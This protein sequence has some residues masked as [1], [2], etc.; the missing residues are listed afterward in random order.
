MT[1]EELKILAHNT[2]ISI[3]HLDKE[4]LASEISEII[5]FSVQINE[6]NF[7]GIF[8]FEHPL[9][10]Q[11]HLREDIVKDSFSP[12]EILLNAPTKKDNFI[13]VPKVF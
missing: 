13:V 11:N 1:Q 8:P 2:H 4:K 6:I 5:E 3:E 9:V 12:Q 7:D 10:P